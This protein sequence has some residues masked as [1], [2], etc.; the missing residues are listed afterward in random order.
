MVLLSLSLVAFAAFLKIYWNLAGV[1]FPV[2]AQEFSTQNKQINYL[3]L[4]TVASKGISKKE[5]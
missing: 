1:G 2:I 3:V 5:S 4:G